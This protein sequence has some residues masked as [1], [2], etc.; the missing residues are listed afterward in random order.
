MKGISVASRKAKGRK[1]Q[2]WVRDQIF[3]L[4]SVLRAED[5]KS[6]PMGVNGPDLQL[7]PFA[8]DIFPWSIECKANKSFAVYKIMEQCEASTPQG[9]VPI[10]VVKGDRKK[11]LVV[12]DAE[13]FFSLHKES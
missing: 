7:S 12:V 6:T 5:I 13:W 1:L 4:S 8:Q 3:N 2:Q 10:V 9:H 11:P